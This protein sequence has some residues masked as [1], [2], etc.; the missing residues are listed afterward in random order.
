MSRSKGI[1]AVRLSRP[2]QHGSAA[3]KPLSEMTDNELHA[4]WLKWDT[5]I[6]VATSWGA[7]LATEYR[8]DCTREMLRRQQAGVT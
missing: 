4:E 3:Q 6:G 5:A 8:E 2:Q 1:S 7:A